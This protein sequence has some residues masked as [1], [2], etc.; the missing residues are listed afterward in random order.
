MVAVGVIWP[1]KLARRQV[2][3]EMGSCRETDKRKS[4]ADRFDSG[5][6]SGILIGRNGVEDLWSVG[7]IGRTCSDVW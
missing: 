4:R 2:K 7:S 1:K 3:P 5:R 6:R